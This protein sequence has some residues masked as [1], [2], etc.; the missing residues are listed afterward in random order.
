MKDAMGHVDRYVSGE[1]W[2]LGDYASVNFDQAKLTQ[3]IKALYYADFMQGVAHLH[4]VRRVAR[5]ASLKDAAE[6]LTQ[7]SGNQSPLLELFSLASTNTDVD[8]PVVKGVFQ[9]VQT[10]VPPGSTDKFIAPPNQNYMNALIALQTAV[11]G[12]ANTA[13]PAQRHSRGHRAHRRQS[14]QDHHAP[15]GAGVQYR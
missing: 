9:P 4:Q 2:V 6:K 8:D 13:R 12:V 10:V 15:D 7:L 14:S 11:E 5:Y 3:D 1:R